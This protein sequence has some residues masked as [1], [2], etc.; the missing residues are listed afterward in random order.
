[1]DDVYDP[2]DEYANV[3]KDKFEQVAKDTFA[4]LA[5]DAQVDVKA[6]EARYFKAIQSPVHQVCSVL[7]I[8]FDCR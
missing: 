2:L 1:M 6:N 5:E 4:R 3:F 7:V 8:F